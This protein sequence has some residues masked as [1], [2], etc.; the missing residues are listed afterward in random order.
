MISIMDR[1]QETNNSGTC[2]LRLNSY[3]SLTTGI[4]AGVSY[5]V[6]C[7]GPNGYNAK[8]CRKSLV[9]GS[10]EDGRNMLVGA[11]EVFSMS[12]GSAAAVP[13]PGSLILMSVGMLGLGVI[14]RKKKKST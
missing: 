1:F 2:S 14:R 8:E 5:G 13:E 11:F 4:S 6:G 7:H 12:A 9:D 3:D 10:Q